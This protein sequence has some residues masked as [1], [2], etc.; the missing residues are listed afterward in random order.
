MTPGTAR[1]QRGAVLLAMLAVVALG[2]SWYLVSR[3]NAERGSIEALRKQR[4]AEVLNRAKQALI[5][6]VAAQAA[7]SGE[8]NPGALPCP[9]AAGYFDNPSREG[10]TASSC[11]LPKVG[12][13]PW[14]TIGTEKLVDAAGEPLWYVVS[15]GW[16]F[17]S[18]N[19]NINSN[20]LGQLTVDGTPNDAVALIIAPGP[21]FS[22]P[23]ATG[24]AAR[25]Q[26]RPT[27]GTPDWRNYL[28]CENA[29]YPT[30]DATFMTTGPSRSFND[31]VIRVTVADIIPGIEAAIAK[32]IEREI[33]PQLRAV[34]GTSTWGLS[35]T[36]PLFPYPAP[37]SK[38]NPG[39]SNYQGA[40]G[41]P[42]GLLPVT[43]VS[44]T[45]DPRCSTSFVAWNQTIPPSVTITGGSGTL[46]PGTTCNFISGGTQA[47]C[48]GRYNA[49]SPVELTLTMTARA[50]NV[51][52]AFR[53]LNA[54][55]VT[56]EYLRAGWDSEYLRAGWD[57]EYFR[58]GWDSEYLRASWNSI[59]ASASGSFVSDGSANIKATA[60]LPNF[61]D[62]SINFRIRIF[63]ITMNISMLADHPIIDS[64]NPTYGWFMR[65]E[66]HRLLYYAVA[67]GF[68]TDVIAAAPQPPACPTSTTVPPLYPFNSSCLSVANVTPAN[69]QRAILILAGRSLNGSSRPSPFPA[70]YFEFGNRTG[71]YE[72]RTVTSSIPG[73]YADTGTA[74]AYAITASVMVGRP[75]QFKAANANTGASTLTATAT[76]ARSLLNPDG[77][78]LTASQ[79]QANAVTEVTYDGTQ[80]TVYKRP[81]NDRVVVIG[82]N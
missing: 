39:T 60:T 16:A 68:T 34:Y 6:Y 23:A 15:P 32:R 38:P 22:V 36:N 20:T 69:S 1:R 72:R 53:Q 49:T 45:G 48:F 75:F 51:A 79:I 3:L 18:G 4:N 31:Q 33:V 61:A 67:R 76:G 10:Q 41:T 30:P 26:V 58:A 27:T 57:S 74:N 19:T 21:A 65:N 14:R 12:L 73:A 5:G 66:W 80:F 44:C 37:F 64:S 77:S 70:D 63:R 24:C 35:S 42:A 13:F 2:G 29:T 28:E 25:N 56:A 7:N 54:S 59:T 71:N 82:S 17:T 55:Q 40:S 62:P 46:L 9:E 8:D 50:G 47:R 43:S 11:T 81:F 78:S 52:M